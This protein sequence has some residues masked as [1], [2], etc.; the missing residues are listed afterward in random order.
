LQLLLEEVQKER[1]KKEL[2]FPT[3]FF[4]NMK[5]RGKKRGHFLGSN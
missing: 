3:S 1:K 5:N 2:L 4:L